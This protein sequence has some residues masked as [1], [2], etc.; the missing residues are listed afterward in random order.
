VLT[1]KLPFLAKTPM[2]Y[3]QKHVMDPPIPL[4]QRVP[5]RQFPPG[6]EAVLAKALAKKPEERFQSAQEFADALRPFGGEQQPPYNPSSGRFSVSSPSPP[7]VSHV[8]P[9]GGAPRS[10]SGKRPGVLLLLGVAAACLVIG[11]LLA[12]LAMRFLGR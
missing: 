4:N 11:V 6:L 8:P 12:V 2:E 10:S 7:A 1:G 3:I 9:T 5:E